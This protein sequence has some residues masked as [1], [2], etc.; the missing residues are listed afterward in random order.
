MPDKDTCLRERCPKKDP[1]WDPNTVE[2]LRKIQEYQDL[3]M[4]GMKLAGKKPTNLVKVRDLRLGPTEA[5]NA[6]YERL[7]QAYQNYTS[8]DFTQPENNREVVMT[9]VAQS[10]PDIWKK[11]SKKEGLGGRSIW[12]VLEVAREVYDRREDEDEKKER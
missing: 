1:K 6:F 8:L 4:E 10:A 11:L 7:M 12:Y 3:F 5:A 2:G 9:F